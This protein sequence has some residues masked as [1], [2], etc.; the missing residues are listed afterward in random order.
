VDLWQENS[1]L[2]VDRWQE[3]DFIFLE[4]SI[5]DFRSYKCVFLEEMVVEGERRRS[6]A[7]DRVGISEGMS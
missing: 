1:H 7:G 6:S 3:Q 2:A 4:F 5:T